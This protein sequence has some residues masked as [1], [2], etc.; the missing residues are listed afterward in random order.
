MAGLPGRFFTTLG[1]GGGGALGFDACE[2]RAGRFVVWV[3]GYQFASKGFG[4]DALGEMVDTAFGRGDFGF[5]L[6]GEGEELFYAADYF[7]LFF[8]LW[9]LK[10]EISNVREIQAR[11]AATVGKLSQFAS[12]RANIFEV[13]FYEWSVFGALKSDQCNVLTNVSLWKR[14]LNSGDFSDVSAGDRD[15]DVLGLNSCSFPFA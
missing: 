4:E 13:K 9:T 6:V 7:G 11:F 2:Q 5:Q 12:A 15:E 10:D 14:L 8:L 3:L 1:F